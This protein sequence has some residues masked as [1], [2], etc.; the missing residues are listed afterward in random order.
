MTKLCAKSARPFLE[1]R[2]LC[3]PP[4]RLKI[5]QSHLFQPGDADKKRI[6]VNA[7]PF[8][9]GLRLRRLGAPR[10]PFAVK[11]SQ[12]QVET[13]FSSGQ[14][15]I[16]QVVSHG[17]QFFGS[18]FIS[19]LFLLPGH[20]PGEKKQGGNENA[21]E[22]LQAVADYLIDAKLTAA[23]YRLYL[24]LTKLDSEGGARGAEPPQPK[25]IMERLGINRDTFFVGIARLKEVGLYDFK[26]RRG[27]A[28]RSG[29]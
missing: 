24:Y 1:A 7:E 6:P 13:V 2:P 22:K 8:H 27:R 12:V 9:D 28:K 14:L 18:V 17:L 20:V 11:L 4:P 19:P 16:D 21:S 15:R 25:A 26:A 23:E 3:P 5:V 10:P 29:L